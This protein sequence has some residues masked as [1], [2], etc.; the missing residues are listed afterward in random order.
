MYLA[1][2]VRAVMVLLGAC[3]GSCTNPPNLCPT[4]RRGGGGAAGTPGHGAAEG[5]YALR[6][7]GGWLGVG[8]AATEQ[9]SPEI[10]EKWVEADFQRFTED[11]IAGW[12][13]LTC[14]GV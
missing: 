14:P 1:C 13:S 5:V 6:M 7:V 10:G 9:L 8:R 12:L 3:W 4:D 11:C 2:G